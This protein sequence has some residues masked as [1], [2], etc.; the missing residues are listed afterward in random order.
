VAANFV[1]W[2]H[3]DPTKFPHVDN[4]R[5]HTTPPSTLTLYE[6]HIGF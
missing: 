3:F 2:E 6:Q 5:L 1:M 4:F